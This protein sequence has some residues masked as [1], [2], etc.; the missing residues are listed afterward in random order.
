[1]PAQKPKI[2]YEDILSKMGMFVSDGKLHLVDRNTLTPQKQQELLNV[3]RQ[4]DQSNQQQSYQQ[5]YQQQYQQPKQYQQPQQ[6]MDDNI[7]KN[8][9]IYNKY[10]KDEVQPQNNIRRPRSLH[11]YK[12]MLVDDYLER[13]RIKQMKSTKLVMPTS[14][15]NMATGHSANLNKLFGFP[16]R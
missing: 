11:E 12:M 7:P 14:N 5:E 2:S 13:Q 4:Y 6:S 10:F 3:Q 16:K 1:M 15:I 8:S 9:Y